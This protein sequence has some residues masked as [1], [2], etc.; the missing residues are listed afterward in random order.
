MAKNKSP[1]LPAGYTTREELLRHP[2]IPATE[3]R[4]VS[5][6]WG[7]KIKQAI[8][9][10]AGF[11]TRLRPITDSI[12]KV[13]V[14][15]GGKPILEHHLLQFKKH[16]VSEFLLNLHYLPEIIKAYIGDGSK[17]GVKVSYSLGASGTAGEVK[18]FEKHLDENFFVIY[19][20]MF[21][22]IDYAKMAESFF[23]KPADALGMMVVGENDHPQDS[24][25]VEVDADMRFLKIHTKPHKELPKKWKSL[26]AV[27]IFRKKILDYI[28]SG[29]IYQIDHN[30]LPDIVSRGEKFYGYEIKDFLLDVGTMERYKKVE[31]YLRKNTHE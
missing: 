14:P 26:D 23:R 3:L 25:L 15:L 8:I 13:M 11:G 28:P 31:E 16:G 24:D 7:D 2:L 19:G 17:W 5:G 6:R 21:S 12:P 1:H 10:C 22:E 30:L 29:A 9:L 27:Y 20:D 18:R 4:G